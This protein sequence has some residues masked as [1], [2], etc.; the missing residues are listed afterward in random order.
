MVYTQESHGCAADM[1]IGRLEIPEFDF[2]GTFLDPGA[3]TQ[4]IV[5]REKPNASSKRNS[6]AGEKS[7]QKE[8]RR[9]T[10]FGVGAGRR[11]YVPRR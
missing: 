4:F 2:F 9:A 8:R 1:D 3:P 11:R 7:G 6:A 5:L 10:A